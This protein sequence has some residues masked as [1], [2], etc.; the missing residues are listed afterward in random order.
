MNHQYT[1]YTDGGCYTRKDGTTSPSYFSFK[2]FKNNSNT[3]PIYAIDRFYLRSLIPFTHQNAK[4][5]I[6]KLGEIINIEND[7]T[8]FIPA[9]CNIFNDKG[10][11][12]N[13]ISEYAAMYYCLARLFTIIKPQ[14]SVEIFSDSQLI[15]NQLL[16]KYKCRQD[17]LIPWYKVTSNLLSKMSVTL[18]WTKRTNIESI[19]GH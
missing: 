3:K 19:L 7:Y 13:N 17:H 1:C 14:Y 16:G 15:I 5:R 12:T 8:L 9:N 10:K 18:T 11:E 4:D 6:G 2:I